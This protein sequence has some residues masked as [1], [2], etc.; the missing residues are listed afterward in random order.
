M[1]SLKKLNAVLSALMFMA[2]PLFF[3]ACKKPCVET[4][5]A[6]STVAPI[7]NNASVTVPTSQ[8]NETSK[9]VDTYIILNDENTTINGKGASFSDSV[10]KISKGGYYS[11][12]GKLSDGK[13]II[14]SKDSE[15]DVFLQLDGVVARS[16]SDSPF[17]VISSERKVHV[18]LSENEVNE[19]SD[20]SGEDSYTARRSGKYTQAVLFSKSDLSIEGSGTL[21]VSAKYK[22]GI[23]SEKEL[24]VLGGNLNVES[25]DDALGA[26]NKIAFMAGTL[27]AS[28]GS[29]GMRTGFSA[30]KG[31]ITIS[32][33]TIK[34]ESGLDCIQSSSTLTVSGGTFDLTSGK[35]STGKAGKRNHS[36]AIPHV[37]SGMTGSSGEQT[38]DAN[39]SKAVRAERSLTV[40]GGN[41][42]VNS[43][44]D[45][46]FCGGKIIITDGNF[47]IK[48]DANAF[49][50]SST[51]AIASG[52][53]NVEYCAEGIE[54]KSV[55]ITGGSVLVN[56]QGHGF[57]ENGNVLQTGGTVVSFG[58]KGEE[59]SKSVYT[60]MG[61]TVFCAGSIPLKQG[62][63]ERCPELTATATF[64]ANTLLAITGLDGKE[65]FCLS[66][67]KSCKS[68]WFSG[69]ELEKG[70]NYKIYSGGINNGVSKNGV[71][72]GSQYTP[73][74]LVDTVAAK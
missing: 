52:N 66:I 33:G 34:I 15:K 57:G 13:I 4:T 64:P 72:Y 68:F 45:A 65:V 31:E 8:S 24:S 11:V 54:G 30:G 53:I 17:S 71:F 35:G 40:S 56:T 43:L 37:S 26:K 14:D 18:I 27:T 29:N 1:H 36:K 73:G 67:A 44:D 70:K 9:K 7:E 62:N 10:L 2:L 38:I 46:F 74:W 48:T 19:F 51:I 39:E 55:Y 69:S 58:S 5:A 59:N 12:K 49:F 25:A 3:A 32:G 21:K 42:A 20:S 63:I 28:S 41:F 16:L 22:K 6:L 23:Y 50:A 60:V 61:G 47:D